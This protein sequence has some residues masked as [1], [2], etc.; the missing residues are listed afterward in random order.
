MSTV[1]WLWA[2][3]WWQ[4]DPAVRVVEHRMDQEAVLLVVGLFAGL[5][6]VALIIDWWRKR[7]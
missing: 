6:V 7:R 4:A 3:L 2:L 1:L 5:C